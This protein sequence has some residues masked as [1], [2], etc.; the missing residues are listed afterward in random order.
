MTAPLARRFTLAVALALASAPLAAADAV[1]AP[2]S[3]ARMAAWGEDLDVARDE[4][5]PRDRSYSSRARADA[6]QRLQR[7]RERIGRLDDVEIAG[8]LARI[9]ALAGNAHTRLY[10]LRNRGHWRRYPLRIWRF[11]DGWRVVAAQREAEA[12]LGARLTHV[13]GRPIETVFARLRPLFAGSRGW[14]RYMGSYTLTSPDALH[15]AGLAGRDGRAE[16]RFEPQG[17]GRSLVLSPSAFERRESVEESWWYL[18]PARDVGAGWRHAIESAR[19]PEALRGASLDYRFLR[20]AG[21][22]VYV[23]FNR[24]ADAP[25]TETVAAWGERLLREIGERPPRR[26][27]FDLRFNTGGDLTKA[28][29]LVEALAASPL[30]RD[31]G[32]I[33]V[34][35]GESTFSAGITPLAVLR[36]T[37]AAIVVGRAPGDGTDFWAEGG[38]VVLPNSRLVLHYA[39]GLHS[40]SGRARAAGIA[41]HV[42]LGLDVADLEPD[43]A[44]RW[45]GTDYAAGRDA[46]VEAA[47][48]APLHC[49]PTERVPPR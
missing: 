23:Q 44:V 35:A 1:A 8:E 40:Y 13:A 6:A 47:L 28:G 22:V 34:L 3:A 25:G 45:T 14:A 7:L 15:A 33:V 39:D 5:L 29:P 21:E 10:L 20:C 9:A 36:G 49:D 41:E 42:A 27:V 2:G 48:G 26:L 43:V 18:S 38:N 37:S 11:A 46:D 30:G 17:A 4:F 31:A 16:F 12:L 19:L 24:A 32:R